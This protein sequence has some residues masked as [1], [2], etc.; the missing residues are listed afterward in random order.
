MQAYDAITMHRRLPPGSLAASGI[1]DALRD[2][3]YYLKQFARHGAIFKMFWSSGDLKICIVGYPLARRLLD[4]NRPFLHPVAIDLT[5]VLPNEY[6]RAMSPKIHPRYRALFVGAF[7]NEL[8][9]GLSPEIAG[10]LRDELDRLAAAGRE[11]GGARLYDALDRMAFRVL[12]RVLLG[13]GS[14][15]ESHAR[16]WA[17]YRRL[18]P[19]G[20]VAPIGAAQRAA[21]RDIHDIVTAIIGGLRDDSGHVG[22]SVLRRMVLAAQSPVDDTVI[23]NLIYMVERGR[24]DLRDLLRWIWKHLCDHPAIVA[25]LRNASRE[26]T[27]RM[28]LA[29]ACVMETLRLEQ[30]EVLV[31]RALVPFSL[32]GYHVPRG[33]WVCT[34]LRET[35]RDPNVF[36]EP[37][38][39]RPHRFLERAYTL[40]EYAPFGLDEHQ[41]I[42]RF[43]NLKVGAML[44][45]TLAKEYA[46]RVVGDGP[47][48]FGMFHWKPSPDFA[49]AL[50]RLS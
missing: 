31:R 26:T 16:M 1:R 49:V 25:E 21:F 33:S 38:A 13:A 43:L 32:D 29:E 42:G 27:A 6:L 19:D 30:A 11:D 15:H 39:Y 36:P 28:P 5:P 9:T 35:H 50:S 14:D 23:G 40:D 47:R 41:C 46:W 45:E 37:D 17:A 7:R 22:D 2:D 44:V 18:G 48:I 10:I 3:R 12:V 20:Y 8:I 24:H 4:R 34:L